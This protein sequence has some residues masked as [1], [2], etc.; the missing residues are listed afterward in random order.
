MKKVFS[1][2]ILTNLFLI[3][4]SVAQVAQDHYCGTSHV[5]NHLLQENPAM[6]D[7]LAKWELQSAL[8]PPVSEK[9]T[10]VFPIVFHIVH[11]YDGNWVTDAQVRDA[12][13]I[14]N[15]DFKGLNADLS[16]V[17]SGF[18]SIIGN[19]DFEFRLARRDPN[20]NCTNGITRTFSRKTFS[21]G[22]NV[23][24]IAQQ[25]DPTKYINVWVV[26]NIA[27]GAGGYAYLPGTAAFMPQR[28]GIVIRAT[29][30][31]GIGFSNGGTFSKR[32]L[33][34]EL[35][36]YFNLLHTWGNSNSPGVASNCS[37]DDNVSDTPNTIGTAS[38]NCNTAQSTCDA[39]VDNI[40][41]IMDYA[42]C[43]LMFS[44]GQATRMLNAANSTTASR[45]NLSS[46]A[47]RNFT[48]V[49]DGFTDTIC[50]PVADFH[51]LNRVV[52]VG[53]P[54]TI[55][56]F[57]YRGNPT[58]YSWEVSDGASN[59]LTSTQATPSFTFTSP[60]IYNVKLTV[61]NT[62]GS[63]TQTKNAYLKVTANSP[64]VTT[65]GYS[66]N[67]ENSPLASGTW[68]AVNEN[69]LGWK[70]T[71]SA[72]VSGSKSLKIDNRTADSL[73]TYYLYSP[74]FDFTQIPDPTIKFKYA[75]LK[76]TNNSACR[77]KISMSS[78]CGQSW[79]LISSLNATALATGNNSSSNFVPLPAQWDEMTVAV[80]SAFKNKPNVRIRFEFVAGNGNNFYFDD[81]NIPGIASTQEEWNMGNALR[82]YPNP[83]NGMFT[84][85]MDLQ[86]GGAGQFKLIDMT[87]KTVWQ[88]EL[89]LQNGTNA[90]PVE[91]RGLK[92]GIY[93][94][95]IHTPGAVLN[96]KLIIQ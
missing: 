69:N 91:T 89:Q 63:S 25:W 82:I 62:A 31:G 4:H 79:N 26:S 7:S 71:T 34:H 12:V 95:N 10:K 83:N 86:E 47:N 39:T 64:E 1:V 45:N 65:N 6:A 73:S 16:S 33:T 15:E 23:K 38:Q 70:E 60:G 58:S 67:F 59:T 28:D 41:N 52:C 32:S 56:N 96:E 20:G 43:P 11:S 84:V 2:F 40:Q 29:Q 36:H 81:F 49:A 54:L 55:N 72:F 35:G 93:W 46:S 8:N 3:H 50:I 9:A 17:I 21:A 92:P 48:G 77:L 5:H 61:S 22:E 19:P 90:Y 24:T 14:I 30:F 87:G 57:T 66:D 44:N 42:S 80:P 13:R 68:F 51:T 94:L 75:Y 85:D 27:S 78:N 18:Q 37:E 53:T 76:R 74:S 88:N